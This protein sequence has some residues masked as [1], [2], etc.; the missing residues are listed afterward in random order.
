MKTILGVLVIVGLAGTLIVMG[1]GMVS[2]FRGGEFNR[3]YGNLLMRGRII[4]QATT[5]ALL[6]LWFFYDDLFL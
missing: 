6:A 4:S 1:A 3:K 5:V 2:M